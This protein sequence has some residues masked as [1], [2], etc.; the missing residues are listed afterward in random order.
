MTHSRW[1][2]RSFVERNDRR[3]PETRT[4]RPPAGACAAE[5]RFRRSALRRRYGTARRPFPPSAERAPP[6][7]PRRAV[8]ERLQVLTS[9]ADVAV[10]CGGFAVT[11]FMQASAAS[12][13]LRAPT[14]FA[15][16]FSEPSFRRPRPLMQARCGTLRRRGAARLG[17]V[18]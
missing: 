9:M 4:T 3:A 10:L 1:I 5:P 2:W 18:V 8:E 6:P 15:L 14:S 16:P 17:G 7:A 12:L 11:T 13:R